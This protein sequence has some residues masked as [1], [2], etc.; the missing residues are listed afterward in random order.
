MDDYYPLQSKPSESSYDP[1]MLLVFIGYM[2]ILWFLI[3]RTPV[4]QQPLFPPR[5]AH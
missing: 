3:G 2:A 4:E 5:I 1:G